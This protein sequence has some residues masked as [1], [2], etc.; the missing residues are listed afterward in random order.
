MFSAEGDRLVGK[1]ARKFLDTFEEVNE[2]DTIP[3]GKARLDFLQP[4]RRKDA[5]RN[6]V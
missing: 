1:A 2:A 5:K 4:G 6:A 3:V